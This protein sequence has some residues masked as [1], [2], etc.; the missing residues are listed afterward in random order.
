MTKIPKAP[1]RRILAEEGA[2]IVTA[3]ALTVF[4]ES[5]EA[6]AEALAVAVKKLARHAGRKTIKAAD[7]KLA[8]DTE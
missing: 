8:T 3:D 4:T 5:V 1:L 2:E 7:V 6:Y